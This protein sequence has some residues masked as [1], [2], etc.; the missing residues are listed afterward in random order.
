MVFIEA[1]FALLQKSIKVLWFDAVDKLVIDGQAAGTAP[2]LGGLNR[3]RRAY[4]WLS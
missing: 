4:I 3:V 2:C 1:P